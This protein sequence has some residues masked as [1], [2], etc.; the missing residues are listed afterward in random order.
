MV[1]KTFCL[2]LAVSTL[3]GVGASA[4]QAARRTTSDTPSSISLASS[5]PHLGGSVSFNVSYPSTVK[6]PRVAVRCFQSGVLVY[7]EAGAASDSFVLGGGSSDW[8]RNG[9]GAQC[10]GEL[11]TM[12]TKPNRPQEYTS[13]AWT[14]FDAAG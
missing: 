9:G 12:V 2:I 8:L 11:F 10:T 5:D 4:A 3:L 1:R 6:D 13:L 7:A 14:S